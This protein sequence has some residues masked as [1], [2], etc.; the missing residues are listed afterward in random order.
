MTKSYR[1]IPAVVF[2]IALW[3]MTALAHA[4]VLLSVTG[5]TLVARGAGVELPVQVTC[6]AGFGESRV[7]FGGMLTQRAGNSTTSASVFGNHT[8]T[9][10]GSPQTIDLLVAVTSPGAPLKPGPAVLSMYADVWSIQSYW[11]FDHGNLRQ[12]IQL[13]YR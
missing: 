9:C 2:G 7:S 4:E 5:G 11:L 1:C 3:S 6:A 12:E 8:V 10:T 13:G